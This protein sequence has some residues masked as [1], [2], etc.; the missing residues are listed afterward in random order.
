[1]TIVLR[2]LMAPGEFYFV[3]RD[4]SSIF[5]GSTLADAEPLQ[6]GFVAAM[7]RAGGWRE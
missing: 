1:M 4:G 6:P 5:A 2:K 3:A 7:A